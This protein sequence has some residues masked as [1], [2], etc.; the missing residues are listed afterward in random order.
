MQRVS[1]HDL[2][3]NA[4]NKLRGNYGQ[5]ILAA[6]VPSLIF[7]LVN[8]FFN[9]LP[10]NLIYIS[11]LIT[12]TLT[13]LGTFMTYTMI[14]RLAKGQRS[15]DFGTSLQPGNRLGKF[16]LF[17]VIIGIITLVLQIPANYAVFGEYFITEDGIN[18]AMSAIDPE[19]P[20]AVEMLFSMVSEWIGFIALSAVVAFIITLP[21]HFVNYII[22]NE[23][24]SIIESCKKSIRYMKGNYF[25]VI[26][27]GLSFIGWNLL[28]L[29]TC[30]LAV[31]YVAPYQE[32]AF[33][34]LYLAIKEEHGEP[35]DMV[36]NDNNEDLQV[37]EDWI[38]EQHQNTNNNNWDF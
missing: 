19:S 17:T 2:R 7:S 32:M 4:R 36:Y 11:S 37:S 38:E 22:V 5:G 28:I 16:V 8:S 33:A 21:L 3:L 35:L 29:V 9:I 31:F 30:G 23:D 15:A 13:S 24:L 1:N 6:I 26:G 25:R 18:Q 20:E 14:L 27:L 10:F 34:N 12:I